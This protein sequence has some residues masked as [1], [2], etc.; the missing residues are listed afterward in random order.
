M[1]NERKTE[2]IV[3]SMLREAGYDGA[4]GIHVEEQKSENPRIKEAFEKRFK[5][6]EWCRFSRFHHK[7]RN[8]L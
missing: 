4:H 3:R 1:A 7:F 6:R 2:R 5:A 8:V